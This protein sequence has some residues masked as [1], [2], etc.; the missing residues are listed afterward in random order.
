MKK[1]IIGGLAVFAISI[2]LLVGS[3]LFKSF[4]GSESALSYTLSATVVML[5]SSFWSNAI[6][7]GYSC[8]YE[9]IAG[10]RGYF[11]QLLRIWAS[12]SR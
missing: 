3:F 2:V 5:T 11:L 4:A 8:H 6:S 10:P 12:S 1:I 7:F 9:Q